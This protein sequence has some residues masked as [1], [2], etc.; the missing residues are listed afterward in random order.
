MEIWIDGSGYNG[1]KSRYII[2]REQGDDERFETDKNMTNNEME[3]K[4]LFNALITAKETD[5]IYTDSQLLDGV[6]NKNWHVKA[7]HL[8]SIVKACKELREIN[9]AKLVWIPRKENKAGILLDNEPYEL[10]Y[11]KKEK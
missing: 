2:Y 7:L 10:K 1:R 5:T 4:A 6:M 3:F 8:L 9:K 11:E